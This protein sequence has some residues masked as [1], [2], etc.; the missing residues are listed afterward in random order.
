MN[1][2]GQAMV[3]LVRDL[4]PGLLLMISVLSWILALACFAQGCSRLLRYA[5]DPFQSP[6]FGAIVMS[7]VLTGA[8]AALPSVL[9]AAGESLFGAG[10]SAASVSLGYGGRAANYEELLRAVFVVVNLVG[11]LAFFR[12]ALLLRAA[13]DGQAGATAGRA[14]TH[15]LGGLAGWY[16]VYVIQAI[17]MSLGIT[18][19]QIT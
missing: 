19:L 1:D 12:G 2:I 17:Q 4:E 15:M 5:R 18:V 16:I 13:A 6:R 8:F 11:L 3:S 14:F 10:A 9:S 7:F